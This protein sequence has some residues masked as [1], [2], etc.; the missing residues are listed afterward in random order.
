MD[1]L[2]N[3]CGETRPNSEFHQNKKMIDGLQA[4]CK[5]CMN[6]STKAYY[7]TDRGKSA[8][9]KAVQTKADEGYFRFGQGAISILKAGAEKRGIE[10]DLTAFTLQKWWHATP[11]V[12]AYCGISIDDYL[13][14]RDALLKYDGHEYGIAKYR[15]FY[16]SPKHQAIRWMTIDR[17]SN[18]LGYA[19]VNMVKSCWICNSLK[20]D[21]FTAKQMRSI[22]PEL[23]AELLTR[24]R[25]TD[26]KLTP[27]AG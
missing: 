7:Q 16:R 20:S 21:F 8:I 15:R 24:L 19:I 10:F 6:A 1:K 26:V 12:C 5:Q 23:I 9:K 18:E 13:A 25:M 2:C 4:Y 11:D 22:S 27:N 3:K 17:V 14:L